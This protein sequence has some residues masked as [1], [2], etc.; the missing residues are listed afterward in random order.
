MPGMRHDT[1]AHLWTEVATLVRGTPTTRHHPCWHGPGRS[2]RCARRLPGGGGHHLH[3]EC[4]RP[5]SVTGQLRLLCH[6]RDPR[7]RDVIW[8]EIDATDLMS[9]DVMSD[10]PNIV[11]SCATPSL[12]APMNR[13]CSPHPPKPSLRTDSTADRLCPPGWVSYWAPPRAAGRAT[14]TMPADLVPSEPV[15]G[16]EPTT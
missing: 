1:N 9:G 4:E 13:G 3:L 5:L 6:H 2:R 11:H 8:F 12:H 7:D 10:A 15:V 16:L 14:E